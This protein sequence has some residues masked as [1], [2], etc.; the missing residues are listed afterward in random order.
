MYNVI[1]LGLVPGTNIQITFGMWLAGGM[2]AALVLVLSS[3]HRSHL[4]RN[5]RIAHSFSR[6]IHRQ[7]LA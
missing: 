1:V 4:I 7:V 2:I 5:W 3:V 6:T